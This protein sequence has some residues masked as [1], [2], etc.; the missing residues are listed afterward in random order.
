MPSFADVSPLLLNRASTTPCSDDM[1]LNKSLEKSTNFI[2]MH[3][4]TAPLPTH[5]DTT[6][7]FAVE[8]MISAMTSR[9]LYSSTHVTSSR[10]YA[11]IN[12]QD[13]NT[14]CAGD[15]R[16]NQARHPSGKTDAGNSRR[17]A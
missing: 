5:L 6:A 2:S 14:A 7:C 11:G 4:T 16:N 12:N 9:S 1:R 3:N 15:T 10:P 13:G 8:S 17:A